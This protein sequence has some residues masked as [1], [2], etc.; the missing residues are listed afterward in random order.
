MEKT[1]V[2]SGLI[3]KNELEFDDKSLSS[4]RRT[5][6]LF[7][8]AL[9]GAKLRYVG[10]IKKE[11]NTYPYDENMRFWVNTNILSRRKTLYI[12]Y[13]DRYDTLPTTEE[14]MVSDDRDDLTISM[15]L[16]DK[17]LKEAAEGPS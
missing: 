5:F 6:R 12:S 15:W 14:D 4:V 11:K 8:F 16:E 9:E 17:G 7:P 1:I 10:F 3:F 2:K 13:S